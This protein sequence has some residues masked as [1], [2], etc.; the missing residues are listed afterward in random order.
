MKVVTNTG[1]D[2][3]K[4][5]GRGKVRDIYD[6]GSELLIVTTDRVSAFDVILPNG[7]PGKGEVLT[8][9][10]EFWFEKTSHIVNNHLIT[11]DIN[12]MP[13]EVQK[14]KDI[15]EGRTMLT[16]KAE[17][18]P[19]ECVA[20]GYISGSGWKDYKASGSICG[21]SL[22]QGLAESQKLQEPIFTPATKEEVGIHDENISFERMKELVGERRALK[23]REL[24]LSLYKFAADYALTKGIIIADTKFEFGIC[25]GDIIL[26]D[27]ALTPDSSRFWN[28]SAYKE[29]VSQ[30][31]MDKQV[32]RDYLDKLDWDKTPPA[33]NLPQDV[34]NKA[35]AK[36]KEI[37]EILTK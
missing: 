3:L 4:L 20:R 10:S 29:G 37:T 26:I 2:G 8:K 18:F 17:P 30:D 1:L 23:L 13:A 6:L 28:K 32:I 12:K 11:T 5:A 35:A 27:E 34:I 7:I 36:Y 16:K 24:T 15:L 22:P 31:S 33:P 21:I 14:H 25:D 19:V 9:I